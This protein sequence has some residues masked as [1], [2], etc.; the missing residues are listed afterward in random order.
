[1]YSFANSPTV[2][3]IACKPTKPQSVAVS[4]GAFEYPTLLFVIILILILHRTITLRVSA[5]TF[6]VSEFFVVQGVYKVSLQFKKIIK[7]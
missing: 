2:D 3:M 6:E 7:K 4:C 5:F 1:M